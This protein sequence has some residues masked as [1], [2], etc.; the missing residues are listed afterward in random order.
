M[1]CLQQTSGGSITGGSRVDGVVLAK[2]QLKF[3]DRPSM[4]LTIANAQTPAPHDNG[5]GR[6]AFLC[7]TDDKGAA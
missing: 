7:Q 4:R 2:R 1:T 5:Q 3:I 6:D